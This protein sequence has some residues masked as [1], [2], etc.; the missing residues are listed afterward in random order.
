V[1]SLGEE[2]IW[3]SPME[4]DLGILVDEKLDL[5][6]ELRSPTVSWAASN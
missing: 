6:Q 5:S 3:S 4:K 2:L 1:D